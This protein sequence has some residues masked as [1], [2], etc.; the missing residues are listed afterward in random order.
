MSVTQLPTVNIGRSKYFIDERLQQLR[1]VDNPHEFYSVKDV[2][3]QERLVAES[4]RPAESPRK[5][6]VV[7][8]FVANFNDQHDVARGVYAHSTIEAARMTYN[9]F[10]EEFKLKGRV[11]VWGD[12]GPEPS[13]FA[14]YAETFCLDED[15]CPACERGE[16]QKIPW[17]TPRGPNGHIMR[18][19][20]CSHTP[21]T[22]TT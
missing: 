12:F 10:S 9:R 3:L 11:M 5:Y 8:T 16:M 18:C 19:K 21:W 17:L 22:P 7:W 14:G 15:P 2:Y 6:T 4:T 20:S 1:N 13:I